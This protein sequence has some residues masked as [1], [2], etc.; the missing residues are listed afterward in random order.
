M[1]TISIA[2]CTYNG[3]RYLSE[4]LASIAAQTR[5][6]D[7]LVVCDDGSKDGTLAILERFAATAPFPVRI[8]RNVVN[9]RSTKNFEKAI[10]LCTGDLIALCDQDDV[11][12]PHKLALQAEQL[13]RDSSIGGVFS[14]GEL[15][16]GRTQ[17]IGRSLWHGIHFTA[18][19]RGQLQAGRAVDVLLRDDVVTGATL[20]VRAN[21][22]SMLLP[23]PSVWV[24]DGWMAW[25]LA[26][27]SR[28]ALIQEPL[29][30]YRVHA[31][32]QIGVESIANASELGFLGRLKKGRRE[33]PAKHRKAAAEM[34]ALQEWLSASH[35]QAQDKVA[36]GVE[37]KRVFLLQRAQIEKGGV[38]VFLQV[39]SNASKYWKYENGWK[40][41]VRDLMLCF[42]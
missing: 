31:G 27:N 9:L 13:E 29:V 2:M 12:L 5:L 14:D 35:N 4:Q 37:A 20:M 22:R 28:L 34:G 8:V 16:N 10:L 41:F 6:P 39:V 32:Q 23:I 40:P 3:S 36:R 19:E 11:W 17:C 1:L 38:G 7:E 30:H 26:L 21:L 24:H 18:R 42:A 25:M 15:I 33:E